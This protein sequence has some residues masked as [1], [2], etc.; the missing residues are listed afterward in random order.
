MESTLTINP[1]I[2]CYLS[3]K[4]K[5]IKLIKGKKITAEQVYELNKDYNPQA[6]RKV[7]D[8]FIDRDAT[9]FYIT[10]CEY[11]AY[12]RFYAIHKFRGGGLIFSSVSYSS[13]MTSNGWSFIK[14]IESDSGEFTFEC[15]V[16]GDNGRLENNEAVRHYIAQLKP[17]I[18]ILSNEF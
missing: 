15:G 1:L 8:R 13:C 4:F 10:P 18:I 11:Y 3:A 9:F 7:I 14:C 17:E 12:P 2:N 6:W 5:P 16:L